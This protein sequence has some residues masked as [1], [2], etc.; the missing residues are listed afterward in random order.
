MKEQ[1]IRQMLMAYGLAMAEQDR[2]K[3]KINEGKTAIPS[4]ALKN[5]YRQLQEA[6]DDITNTFIKFAENEND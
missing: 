6:R 4:L 5:K 3:Q 2:I 1:E